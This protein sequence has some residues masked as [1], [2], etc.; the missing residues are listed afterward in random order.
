[1][2]LASKINRIFN[3]ANRRYGKPYLEAVPPLSSWTLPAGY[4]ADATLDGIRTGSGEVLTDLDAFETSGY[5]NLSTVYIV[6]LQSS[7]DL[8]SMI[9]AGIAPAGQLELYVLAAD[10]PTVR[11]AFAIQVNGQWYDVAGPAAEPSGATDVWARV[12][13]QRRA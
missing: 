5:F 2:T 3:L 10:L 1:M 7:D 13:L 8:R 11:A 12:R 6:P 9:A 4:T